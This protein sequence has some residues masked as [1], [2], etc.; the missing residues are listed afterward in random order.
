MIW[1]GDNNCLL[2]FL[3]L[4]VSFQ[5][6]SSSLST[7]VSVYSPASPVLFALRH[8]TLVYCN[9]TFLATPC[10]SD[11]QLRSCVHNQLSCNQRLQMHY[12]NKCF[13]NSQKHF[14]LSLSF[15]LYSNTFCS[16]SSSS[17]IYG[18]CFALLARCSRRQV[19]E[20]VSRQ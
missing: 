14:R 4:G 7:V 16:S 13:Q 11:H 19:R 15:R 5:F 3:P 12:W 6:F 17:A 9:C 10:Q 1:R 2:L 18:L 20:A 8:I